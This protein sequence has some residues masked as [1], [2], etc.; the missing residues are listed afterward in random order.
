MGFERSK[1]YN[2]ILKFS[3][4]CCVFESLF[5]LLDCCCLRLPLPKQRCHLANSTAATQSLSFVCF[6][7]KP[8]SLIF[9]KLNETAKWDNTLDNKT[10]ECKINNRKIISILN[11][12]L[13]WLLMFSAW[14]RLWPNGSLAVG[15]CGHPCLTPRFLP[16][17]A[18]SITD[19]WECPV[20]FQTK[21]WAKQTWTLP[22]QHRPSSSNSIVPSAM[23]FSSSTSFPLARHRWHGLHI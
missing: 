20:V 10:G 7:D 13:K 9:V 15:L 21:V 1:K 17:E 6:G 3:F 12:T 4:A 8:F 2:S 5:A 23:P 22:N 16:D 14:I 18:N 19:N 11:V